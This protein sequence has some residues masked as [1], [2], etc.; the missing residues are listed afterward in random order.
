M[1]LSDIENKT[2]QFL[3]ATSFTI[4]EFELLHFLFSESF[5][6][7]IRYITL[8]GK[9]KQRSFTI[10]KNSIF[11][12]TKDMLLFII[13][14]MKNSPLQEYQAIL[15]KIYQPKANMY[16]HLFTKIIQKSLKDNKHAPLRE[17][18]NLN[19]K[20]SNSASKYIY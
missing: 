5:A 17:G 19:E 2:T 20:L 3:S 8:D 12:N 9:I 14:Y 13:M 15:F 7:Y 1:R 6:E 10:R 11:Q 16:I 4:D 18:K